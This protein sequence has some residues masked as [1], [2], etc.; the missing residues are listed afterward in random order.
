MRNRSAVVAMAF[1]TVGGVA[2]ADIQVDSYVQD[3]LI[4]QWDGIDNAGTGTHDPNVTT[5]KELV[6]NLPTTA[7]ALTFDGNSVV[8]NGTDTQVEGNIGAADRF[9]PEITV[10]GAFTGVTAVFGA[11]TRLE[12]LQTTGAQWVITPC[13]PAG[14]DKVEMKVRVSDFSANQCFFCS[15]GTAANKTTM[16]GFLLA[17]TRTLRF[18]RSATTTSTCGYEPISGRD[19]TL[20]VDYGAALAAYAN[21]DKVQSL[22]SGTFTPVSKFTLFASHTAGSALAESSSVANFARYRFYGFSVWDAAGA[23]KAQLVP[24][25]DNAAEPGSPREY[26]VLDLVSGT[27]CP[28]LGTEPFI[29]GCPEVDDNAALMV[30][31]DGAGAVTPA[32]GK[33]IAADGATVNCTAETGTDDEAGTRDVP[34]GYTLETYDREAGAWSA[35][36]YHAGT[37]YAHVQSGTAVTRLTWKWRRQVRLAVTPVCR[38][39]STAAGAI[40]VDGGTAASAVEGWFDA[41]TNVTLTASAADGYAFA[42]WEGQV[43]DDKWMEE[44]PVVVTMDRPRT[45]PARFH[46]DAEYWVYENKV[47]SNVLT[48][49]ALNVTLS[50]TNITFSSVKAID[51]DGIIDL[52]LR[53]FS[54]DKS[55]EYE[56]TTL[57][58]SCMSDNTTVKQLHLPD[59]VTSLPYY[60]MCRAANQ[61]VFRMPRRVTKIDTRFFQGQS[62]LTNIYGGRLCPE[63]LTSLGAAAFY[64]LGVKGAIL[65]SNPAITTLPNEFLR[66]SAMTT[67]DFTGTSIKKISGTATIFANAAKVQ[68]ITWP[69]TFEQFSSS[70]DAACGS[71]G[72]RIRFR[73]NPPLISTSDPFSSCKYRTIYAPKWNKAWEQYLADQ[74]DCTVSDMTSDACATFVTGHPGEALPLIRISMNGITAAIPLKWWYPDEPPVY[75]DLVLADV[76]GYEEKSAVISENDETLFDGT[77]YTWNG[78]QAQFRWVAAEGHAATI[79]IPSAAEMTRRAKFTKYR[80]HQLCLGTSPNG[81]APTA[82]TLYGKALDS[83]EWT[84]IDSVEMTGASPAHWAYFDYEAFSE[85]VPER[86]ACALTFDVPTEK[87]G[88]YKA[89]KFLPTNSYNKDYGV[90]DETPYGLMELELI[91]QLTTPGPEID[92]IA[93]AA[94]QWNSIDFT[95]VVSGLGEIPARGIAAQEAWGWVEVAADAEFAEFVSAS[96]TNAIT[97]WAEQT[98]AVSNLTGNTAYYARFVVSNDLDAVS[99]KVLEGGA[100]TLPEPFV[101]ARPACKTDGEGAVTVHFD[102]EEYY[103]AG[104]GTVRLYVGDMPGGTYVADGPAQAVSAAGAFD[105]AMTRPAEGDTPCVKVVVSVDGVE[106]TYITGVRPFWI[107]NAEKSPTVISN[108]VH[109]IGFMVSDFDKSGTNL[110]LGAFW[111]GKDAATSVDLSTPISSPTTNRFNL[112]SM[113]TTFNDNQVIEEVVMPDTVTTLPNYSFYSCGKLTKIHLSTNLQTIGEYC[114]EYCRSLSEIDPCLPDSVTKIGGYAFMEC[115]SIR[116]LTLP[117]S[118]T[119]LY[120]YEFSSCTGL[121]VL[122]FPDKALA[123]GNQSFSRCTSLSNVTPRLFPKG[124]TVTTRSF[125]SCTSLEGDAILETEGTF[126]LKEQSLSNLSKVTSLDF[127]RC[128]DVSFDGNDSC[129]GMNALT[130]VVFPV[131]F[132]GFANRSCIP[133]ASLKRVEFRGPPPTVGATAPLS[134]T[135]GYMFVI[136]VT[137]EPGA[138]WETYLVEHPDW[139]RSMTS[140]EKTAFRKAFPGV[141]GVK[142]MLNLGGVTG[143]HYLKQH[144]P[145]LMIMVK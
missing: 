59:A 32:V 98:Y 93:V 137:G 145:G 141:K 69:K 119:A 138:A 116:E 36:V 79:E 96:S 47:L 132:T 107:A 39:G 62:K 142:L 52:T 71:A 34:V 61:E 22:A 125:L 53:K 31:S 105:L 89:F 66:S 103:A 9:S 17:D 68:T 126:A 83:D 94:P 11:Y 1:C 33:A 44:N 120:S 101:C 129:A 110:T 41:G 55:K 67:V 115:K 121:G 134:T 6:G 18:D 92:A 4:S 65:F 77:T 97:A 82:W 104:A 30:V 74:T 78:Q 21:G 114:F 58:N 88:C 135:A 133:S 87:Q 75:E 136:P 7:T 29:P 54:A 25:K 80:L 46:S 50:A 70:T 106:R 15:R 102:V 140:A 122:H 10:T 60:G 99:V 108:S 38:D 76:L 49:C 20:T 130:N 112:L 35:P 128:G 90:A 14:T 40:S 16:T 143:F 63:T 86:T 13:K 12:W 91:G 123:M 56:V 117:A 127:S 100:S 64:S 81:R 2:L 3:G 51:A 27:F 19:L 73:G 42:R 85:T 113:G 84:V 37:A 131:G 26:G 8:F 48:H 109:D 139:V 95:G 24:A 28:N 72:R 23:L 43:R 5:W 57:A 118:L 124:M 144:D 45:I 111:Y